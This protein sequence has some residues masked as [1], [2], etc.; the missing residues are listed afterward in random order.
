MEIIDEAV[1]ESI[2]ESIDKMDVKNHIAILK[3][4]KS[5]KKVTL[6]ENMNGFY[7]NLSFL[8]I[9]TVNEIEKYIKYIDD[10]EK[11][12]VV[13]EDKKREMSILLDDEDNE[14]LT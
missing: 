6:N 3:I 13:F 7:I 10:Q 11:S 1:L 12:F 4:L 8:P 2:K 5:N 14:T 9:E